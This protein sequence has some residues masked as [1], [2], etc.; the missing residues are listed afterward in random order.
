MRFFRFFNRM[1]NKIFVLIVFTTVV[2]SAAIFTI[3]YN[4]FFKLMADDVRTRT[5]N[6]NYYAQKWITQEAFTMLHTSQDEQSTTYLGA[7]NQLNRI[8]QI[9][10]VR[11]LFTAKRN[12]EGKIVYVVDGLPPQS[13]DFRHIGDLVEPEILDDLNMCLD[14]KQVNIDKIMNTDWGSILLTCWPKFDAQNRV[15]GAIVMEYDA[16]AMYEKNIRSM[17]YSVGVAVLI[18]GLCIVLANFVLRKVSETFYKNLAYT[19][20]LTGLRSR[21]AFETDLEQLQKSVISVASGTSGVVIVVYDLNRL[22]VINDNFGHSAGDNYIKRM[23]EVILSIS[24]EGARHYRIGGDEFVT[25]ACCGPAEDVRKQL[26]QCFNQSRHPDMCE[27]FFEF[28]YGIATFDP[29][30]DLSLQDTMNR[31]D[32]AMYEFK[33]EIKRENKADSNVNQGSDSDL[34]I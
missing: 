28:S 15:V 27:S 7:Q 32:S 30:Q 25:V 8:R 1:E 12:D 18:A 10:N 21:L 24:L 16:D 14:G 2:S 20:V 13:E 5:T 34:Y 23:G 9:A 29:E 19:D 26:E 6:V 17:Y 33:R 11:Y 4:T 3:M 31:A 22:K